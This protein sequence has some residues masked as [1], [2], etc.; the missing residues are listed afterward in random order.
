MFQ[1]LGVV[2]QRVHVTGSTQGQ[3]A[4]PPSSQSAHR[5]HGNSTTQSTFGSPA[6]SPG[7]NPLSDEAPGENTRQPT[8]DKLTTEPAKDPFRKD[9][10]GYDANPL[11]HRQTDLVEYTACLSVSVCLS[12]CLSFVPNVDDPAPHLW[13]ACHLHTTGAL[14]VTHH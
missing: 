11:Q 2:R 12:V 14:M 1:K 9:I 5:S 4:L 6:K 3:Q 8:H 13:S 7:F 10:G